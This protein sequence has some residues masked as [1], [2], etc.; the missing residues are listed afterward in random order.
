MAEDPYP[1]NAGVDGTAVAR[2]V[3]GVLVLLLGLGIALWILVLV[4][5][6]IGGKELMPV[7]ER[8][9]TAASADDELLRHYTDLDGRTLG[10]V[11]GYLVAVFLLYIAAGIAKAVI[12]AGVGLM[13]PDYKKVLGELQAELR[14][15]RAS[16]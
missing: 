11:A 16:K 3:S 14:K 1:G 12:G 15:G 10:T 13:N 7:V 6:A 9:V 2:T 8:I 4:A 5:Q